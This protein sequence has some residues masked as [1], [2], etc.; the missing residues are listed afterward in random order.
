MSV[1]LRIVPESLASGLPLTQVD[2]LWHVYPSIL[3]LA[4][5]LG[6]LA[7]HLVVQ[8]GNETSVD[9]V[10]LALLAKYL[11]RRTPPRVR[12]APLGVT[13]QKVQPSVAAA[14]RE[15][16]TMIKAQRP[17]ASSVLVGYSLTGQAQS[18]AT[19]IAR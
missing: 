6:Q 9:G 13:L 14:R 7:V 19:M 2:D 4:M 11:Q 8:Q 15:S 12:Y 16:T 18:A 3:P 1:W 5:I 10:N 17:H